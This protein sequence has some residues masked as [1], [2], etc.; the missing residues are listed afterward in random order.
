MKMSQFAMT[1]QASGRKGDIPPSAQ[2]NSMVEASFSP[3]KE[4]VEC[5]KCGK[6]SIVRRSADLFEC[7]NCSFHKELTP[8]SVSRRANLF[9]VPGQASK[10]EGVSRGL[11]LHQQEPLHS[12]GIGYPSVKSSGGSLS[13]SLY[14]HGLSSLEPAAKPDRIQPLI[15][16]ALAV[17]FGILLL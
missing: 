10:P 6:R 16:A 15:F 7:L 2:V 1:S 11:S 8:V 3:W 4:A 5:P 17:I 9:S 13:E 14:S 12:E